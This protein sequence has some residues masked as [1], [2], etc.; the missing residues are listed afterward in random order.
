VSIC[1]ICGLFSYAAPLAEGGVEFFLLKCYLERLRDQLGLTGSQVEKIRPVLEAA[2]AKL[3]KIPSDSRYMGHE[4]R[5]EAVEQV[6]RWQDRQIEA[7]LT[8][9][10]KI[11]YQQIKERRKRRPEG[12]PHLP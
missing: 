6:H 7:L 1:V 2:A 11:R 5:R 9:R 12:P 3:E 10:Q 8:D 4:E